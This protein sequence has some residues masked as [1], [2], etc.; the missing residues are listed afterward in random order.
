MAGTLSSAPCYAMPQP[1]PSDVPVPRHERVVLE[2][3][4][5]LIVIPRPE[6]PLIAFQAVLR[7]G[8][9]GDPH[10][11]PGVSALIAG[12]LDKGAGARDAFAF[13]DEVE[14]VGG[15]FMASAGS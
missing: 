13:A 10:D 1:G 11:R 8:A 3:G 6:V 15:S 14:G 2:N 5:T 9:L 7:G 12:L 4:I